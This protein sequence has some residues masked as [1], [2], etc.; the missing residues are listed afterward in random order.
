[1]FHGSH[2]SVE[3]DKSC[4]MNQ[5]TQCE[6]FSCIGKR[7]RMFLYRDLI[8][9]PSYVSLRSVFHLIPSPNHCWTGCGRLMPFMPLGAAW[10]RQWG[11]RSLRMSYY[12]FLWYLQYVDLRAVQPPDT[13]CSMTMVYVE[14]GLA[15]PYCRSRTYALYNV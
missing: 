11:R 8:S 5:R 14:L 15:Y 2:N 3:A 6:K 7:P 13:E 4:V 10:D 9:Y 12:T 1:M